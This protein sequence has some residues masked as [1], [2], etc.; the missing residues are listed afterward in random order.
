MQTIAR[1]VPCETRLA[2]IGTDHARLPIALVVDGRIKSAVA[3]DVNPGPFQTALRNVAASGL[4]EQISVRH[5]NGLHTL[6]EADDIDT[7]AIA[8]MGGNLITDI[9]THDKG[10]LKNV[11]SLILQPNVAADIV[12]KWLYTKG[13]QLKAEYVI[14]EDERFYEVLTAVKGSPDQAYENKDW[15]AALM[16]GPKLLENKTNT[17]RTKWQHELEHLQR[18]LEQMNAA[19]ERRDIVSERERLKERIK[20]IEEVL[21]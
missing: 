1:E 20:K 6:T 14:Q 19:H 9:L 18:V 21:T 16:F 8:G 7:I 15:E 13:W 17:F 2:D 4:S 3:S 12:R 10:I 5:G 11:E